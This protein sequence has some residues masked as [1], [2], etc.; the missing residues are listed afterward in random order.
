VAEQP[1]RGAVPLSERLCGQEGSTRKIKGVGE[2]LTSR[3]DSRALEE[4][5]G[6]REALGQRRQSSSCSVK[7]PVSGEWAKQRAGGKPEGVS[8]C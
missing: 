1:N 5:L 4:R 2:L 7:R 8:H 3:G 6:H